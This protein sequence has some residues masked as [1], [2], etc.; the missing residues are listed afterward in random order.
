M[1]Y[2]LSTYRSRYANCIAAVVSLGFLLVAGFSLPAGV[3][4]DGGLSSGQ[5]K[6]LITRV[7]G[8]SLKSSAIRVLRTNAVD[9]ST[10]E[11]TAEIETAFRLERKNDTGWQA[12]EV[13]LGQDQWE[14]IAVIGAGVNSF[15]PA[16]C[17]AA[18]AARKS[19]ELSNRRA[20]CVLANLIGVTLPSDAVRIKEISA[21]LPLASTQ[22]ALV[23][24]IVTLDF[25][26]SREGKSDWKLSGVRG[27]SH[28]W[29]DPEQVSAAINNSK[30]SQ[31]RAEMQM[32]AAALERFRAKRGS[33]ITS[34]NHAVLIDL[35]SPDF[36]SRIIRV[37]P[38]QRPYEYDGTSDHFTLR[39][40]GPDR[41]PNTP[42]DIVLNGPAK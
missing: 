25:R 21:G 33:Y 29:V 2:Q 41:K 35:L 28:A 11:A 6:R 14:S 17:E 26:F 31:A 4:A 20:R 32:I 18:D 13:R 23:E 7:G 1:S 22:S 30:T 27:G 16:N 39:S 24:A 15:Q 36:L 42:D 9:S 40:A 5:A 38:W 10:S 12:T 8:A 37:D 19:T 3:R 34:K